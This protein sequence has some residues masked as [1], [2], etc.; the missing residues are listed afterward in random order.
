MMP[1][2][3]E[4]PEPVCE[5]LRALHGDPI[6]LEEL[7]GGMG[8]SRVYRIRCATGSVV[9]KR[10]PHPTEIAF[11]QRAAPRLR[12]AGIALPDCDGIV[13]ASDGDWLLLEDIPPLRMVAGAIS[14]DQRMVE[15]LARL[16]AVS[17]DW[18]LNLPPWTVK[19]WTDA[20]T[21]DALRLLPAAEAADLVPTLA[22]LQRAARR[23]ET[24]WCWISGDPNRTNW[25]ERADGSLVLFDWER[26]RRG[27]PATD[28]AILIGGLGDSE[29][30]A[31]LARRYRV[32]W[33]DNARA[34]PWSSEDLA[35]DI[36]V[37][38]ALTVVEF[39]AL[40]ARGAVRPAA[41]LFPWL[42]DAAPS[43]LHAIRAAQAD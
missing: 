40:A 43:W 10:A 35:R 30:Y 38:K 13:A 28:L 22:A 8:R 37:A 18:T 26:C 34:L 15:S 17:R 27:L 7:H 33:R 41:G 12:A 5:R 21:Q 16:H 9:A 6:S 24:P 4:L 20:L 1:M 3:A 25:G 42:V 29:V 31:D 32:A 36:A 39:L 2:L 23:L 11:Y 14:P 19:A